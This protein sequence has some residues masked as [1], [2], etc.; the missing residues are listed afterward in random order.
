MCMY[1][2]KINSTSDSSE[3][4]ENR[5]TEL[6]TAISIFFKHSLKSDETS[7]KDYVENYTIPYLLEFRIE[8][9]LET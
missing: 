3:Q 2:N 8:R 9:F 6:N 7:Y 5:W 1:T 4:L